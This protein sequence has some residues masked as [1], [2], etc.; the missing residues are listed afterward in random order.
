MRLVPLQSGSAGNC[1]LVEGGGT[2]VL[3]D[4]GIS[5]KRTSERL[6]AAGVEIASIDAILISHDHS[7]H[8]AAAGI[9]ARRHG[10]R[11]YL[12][13][14]TWRA[15]HEH[16]GAQTPCQHFTAGA[17]LRIGGLTIE[18]IPTPHD[19]VDGVV[20]VVS[21]GQRRLGILTDFGH[22]FAWLPG[23]V[24]QLDAVYLE[25]NYDA[26]MLADGPYP[27]ALKRRIAGPGGHIS[28][29]E[30][31]ELLAA[32]GRRLQWAC[33]AHLSQTNNTPQRAL[34]THR[35]I[36]GQDLPLTIAAYTRAS[37]ALAVR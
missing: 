32:R 35:R 6:A 9:L 8:V 36:H 33:L 23:I 34:A 5:A 21:D 18:T 24:E 28:N 2:R 30:S 17:T 13:E 1:I 7:D 14:P 10:R 31:A 3:F 22:V 4:A 20:F 11:V 29:D 19:A 15:I 27:P 25:S 12:T 26:A 37:E 16:F